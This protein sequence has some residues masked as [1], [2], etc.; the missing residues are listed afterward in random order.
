M[1]NDWAHWTGETEGDKKICDNYLIHLYQDDKPLFWAT[2]K[3]IKAQNK[4]CNYI[5]TDA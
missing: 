5:T 4:M 1:K 2:V 3:D